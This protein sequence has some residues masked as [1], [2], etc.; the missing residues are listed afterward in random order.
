[1]PPPSP[2]F[3]RARRDR[4]APSRHQGRRRRSRLALLEVA[5]TAVAAVEEKRWEKEQLVKVEE[6]QAVHAQ[7]LRLG[8]PSALCTRRKVPRRLS[9]PMAALAAAERARLWLGSWREGDQRPP[10]L[11]MA[12]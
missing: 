11:R 12:R 8:L 7:F 10:P 4:P 9:A 3:A 2:R 1:M 5:A 6:E